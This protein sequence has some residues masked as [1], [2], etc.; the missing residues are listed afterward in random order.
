MV[1]RDA[2][3][4]RQVVDNSKKNFLNNDLKIAILRSPV[5]SDRI[6]SCLN[7]GK[8]IFTDSRKNL[9]KPVFQEIL[10]KKVPAQMAF[11]FKNSDI[12]AIEFVDILNHVLDCNNYH[13]VLKDQI[14]TSA[15]EA[16]AN[17]FLWS[18]L[19]LDSVKGVRPIEFFKKI[20]EKLQNP[21]YAD[22]Y[23]GI[24]LAKYPSAL[25]I[26]IYV[27]GVPIVWPETI[28]KDKFRGLNLIVNLTDKVVIDST[29]KVIRLY[30]FG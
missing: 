8:S 15:Q 20:E 1:K 2:V 12:Y 26:S 23:M 16:Y 6:I 7:D 17:A 5:S 3:L 19:D 30:F 29:G 11:C 9:S 10:S 21:I 24:C 28:S 4:P 13:P 22:R 14:L 27:E 25:E 18:S